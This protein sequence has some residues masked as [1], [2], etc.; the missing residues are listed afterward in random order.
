MIVVFDVI[1]E[2]IVNRFQIEKQIICLADF[3]IDLRPLRGEDGIRWLQQQQNAYKQSVNQ[4]DI[5]FPS[6]AVTISMVLEPYRPEHSP[7]S[8]MSVNRY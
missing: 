1:V 2:E 7:W 4:Y 8:T 5:K 3:A 6:F